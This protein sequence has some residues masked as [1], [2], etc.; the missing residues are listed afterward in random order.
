MAP[1]PS[2][3]VDV[4]DEPLI[5]ES[6]RVSKG[7]GR[8]FSRRRTELC[9][10]D[11][12]DAYYHCSCGSPVS[13]SRIKVRFE[14]NLLYSLK[15]NKFVIDPAMAS[16]DWLPIR[17]TCQ[18]SSMKRVIELWSATVW[19]TKFSFAN[20]VEVSSSFCCAAQS[21]WSE[22]GVVTGIVRLA[23]NRRQHMVVPAVGIV[24][25]DQNRHIFPFGGFL[26][27]VDDG[28]E[29]GLLQQRA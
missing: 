7:S 9:E 25:G 16:K 12:C 22:Q 28:H 29:K 19:E 3:F 11:K 20:G 6:D 18:L 21:G 27:L 23:H 1:A 26:Q 2:T 5:R 10:R 15:S 8:S 13:G 24:P 14:W 17:P 4:C